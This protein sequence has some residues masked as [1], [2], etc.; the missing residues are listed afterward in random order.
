MATTEFKAFGIGTGTDVTSQSEYAAASWRDNGWRSGILPHQQIN[1][2]IRQSSVV[3]AAF[4]QVIA[5]V[6]GTNIADDGNLT[7][8][9]NLIGNVLSAALPYNS[10]GSYG[11]NTIGSTLQGL[12]TGLGSGLTVD[13]LKATLTG[14]LTENELW[15]SLRNRINLIDAA[16]TGLVTKVSDLT[17]TYGPGW[18]NRA[19]KGRAG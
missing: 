7:N 18:F 1:K 5:T 11:A 17:A 14:Q 16:G 13:G 4:T 19:G 2:A 12:V 15:P 6:S 10:A 3:T 8:L 9:T